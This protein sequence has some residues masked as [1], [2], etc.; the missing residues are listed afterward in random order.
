MTPLDNLVKIDH[1]LLVLLN[2]LVC[3]CSLVNVNDFCWHSLYAARKGEDSFFKLFKAAVAQ[4]NVVEHIWLVS[5][6]WLVLQRT[7]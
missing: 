6:V 4:T 7:L 2:H 1:G 3:F 5:V